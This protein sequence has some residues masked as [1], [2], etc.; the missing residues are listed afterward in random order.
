MYVF[1]VCIYSYFFVNAF[2]YDGLFNIISNDMI[3]IYK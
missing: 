2:P 3:T 1:Y